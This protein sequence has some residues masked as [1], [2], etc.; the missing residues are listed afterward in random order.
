MNTIHMPSVLKAGGAAAAVAVILGVLS[1]IPVIG[2][3]IGFCFLC[4]GILIPIGAGL[5]YGYF[6]PG[7]EDTQTAA[8]GGALSGGA[9]GLILAVFSAISGS[10]AAGVQQGV[11]EG[12]AAGLFG[13]L[14]GILCFGVLGFVLG[15]IGGVLWPVIQNQRAL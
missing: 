6:A 2:P 3:I 13:G 14:F 5:G 4:G 1:Y 7:K 10:I 9:S 15:A 12:L 11:G 8:V